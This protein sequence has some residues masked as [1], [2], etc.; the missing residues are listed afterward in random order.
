M[1]YCAKCGVEVDDSYKNCPLCHFPIPDISIDHKQAV[2]PRFPDV[3]DVYM[4]LAV[5]F[6]KKLFYAMTLLLLGNAIGFIYVNFMTEGRLSWALYTGITFF[7]LW[8]Y[9]IF[10]FR[11]VRS[12]SKSI[13]GVGINTLVLL[14]GLDIINGKFEWFVPLGLPAVFMALVF[15]LINY[16]MWMKSK[17]KG[18]HTVAFSLFLIIGYCVGLEFFISGYLH[19]VSTLIWSVTVT[20]NI[21]PL[22]LLLLYIHYQIPAWIK[23]EIKKRFHI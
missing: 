8:V 22:A 1:P 2:E 12:I 3:K 20:M 23:E 9:L 18:L 14:A 10:I 21:L 16:Y 17:N 5:D 19:G 7:S 15:L 6:K 13:I 11:Y 4:Q